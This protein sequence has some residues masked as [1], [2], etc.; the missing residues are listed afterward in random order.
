MTEG[1]RRTGDER[2]AELARIW[3]RNLAALIH[4]FGWR[5]AHSQI[6]GNKF[7]ICMR[8]DEG[9][10]LWLRLIRGHR[11]MAYVAKAPG[12][13]RLQTGGHVVTR[14]GGLEGAQRLVFDRCVKPLS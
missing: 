9:R 2:R 6:Q 1:E 12:S 8:D 10:E 5:T 7:A 11:W 13:A 14:T 3:L 4:D